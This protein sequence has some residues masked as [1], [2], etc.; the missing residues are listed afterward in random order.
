M[1]KVSVVVPVYN[2]G[3]Y[4][5]PCIESLTSQSLPQDE[6]EVICVDDGSTDDTP[7][8]LDKLAATYPNIRVIHQPNSG[9]PGQPRN[10]ALLE[11]GCWV[12]HPSNVGTNK[13]G[14]V[15]RL[16]NWLDAHRLK[17]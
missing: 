16:T 17:L 6:F 14:T 11:Y 8:R 4:F 2:P 3:D 12:H 5:T 13:V 1:F 15:V 7:A 9:W 10:A